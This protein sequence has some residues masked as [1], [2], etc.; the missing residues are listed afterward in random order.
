[1][2]E[3]WLGQ[4]LGTGDVSSPRMRGAIE[5]WYRL[6]YGDGESGT[7]AMR[8]LQ[9][10]GEYD[11]CQQ[12]PYTIVRKLVSAVFA[13]YKASG[14]GVAGA[15]A[16]ALEPL[17]REAVAQALIGGECY[18]RPREDGRSGWMCVPRRNLLILER[19]PMGEP[20]DIAM[21]MELPGHTLV[22]RRTL[23]NG[24][25]TVENRL[26]RGKRAV[27]LE[28]LPQLAGLQERYVYPQA[29][30]SVGL[31]R[32]RTPMANCVDGS[33]EGVSVYAPAV[34]LIRRIGENEAQLAGE[35][36]RG[37]S[38]LVVSRDMLSDGQL[39][40]DVFVA[41]DDSPES[42]G[43]TVFSPELR[44]QS[45]LN[46]Q[47]AYLRSVENVVGLKRGLLSQVEAVERTATEV[48]SSQ[49]EYAMTIRDFQEMWRVAL[50][51]AAELAAKLSG[52][53]PGQLQVEFGDGML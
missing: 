53:E 24:V 19:D 20:V 3:D 39:K 26:F 43:I 46:R 13:E 44:E 33:L 10:A 18:L 16:K 34:G 17:R 47:Q 50:G 35:F 14:S 36:R 42:V 31:V 9:G 8:A 4:V 25:L 41:L 1:M 52:K 23:E 28:A 6:Y 27:P 38:R 12:I 45:Y 15:V 49:G 7:H 5:E 37:Q 40:D 48:T 51:K 21:A 11:P 22:E 2:M 29:M 32:M 30:N